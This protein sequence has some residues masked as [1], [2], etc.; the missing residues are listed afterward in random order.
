M[1]KDS[2]PNQNKRELRSQ[3]Q[4]GDIELDLVIERARLRAERDFQLEQQASNRPRAQRSISL[5]VE[6]TPRETS[7]LPRL[8]QEM[9]DE[10]V[11]EIFQQIQLIL[12]SIV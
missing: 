6:G 9:S 5:P 4:F 11:D 8:S 3:F 7:H 10:L 2:D 1:Q 12:Y